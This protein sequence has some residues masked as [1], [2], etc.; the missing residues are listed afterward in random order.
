[1]TPAASPRNE[2]LKSGTLMSPANLIVA[3]ILGLLAMGYVS[4]WRI[5]PRTQPEFD[6]AIRYGT[7][8]RP[9]GSHHLLHAR[10]S[11]TAKLEPASE[12]AEGP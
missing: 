1:M 7:T 10:Q 2:I 8:E 4:D 3:G 9:V 5:L 12:I 11:L 6:S